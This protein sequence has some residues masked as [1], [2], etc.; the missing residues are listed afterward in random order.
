MDEGSGL[1]FSFVAAD[2]GIMIMATT[3]QPRR[4]RR[5]F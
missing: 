2:R 5:I 3:A 1:L 4:V